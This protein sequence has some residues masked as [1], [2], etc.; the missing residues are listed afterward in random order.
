M[1]QTPEPQLTLQNLED[2]SAN[3]DT[4]EQSD[5]ESISSHA[6][7]HTIDTVTDRH[8][9]TVETFTNSMAELLRM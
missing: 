4:S 3:K 5:Q 1:S 6:S 8:I 9:D 7:I 2:A